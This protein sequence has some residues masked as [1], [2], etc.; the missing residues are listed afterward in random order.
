M[1]KDWVSRAYDSVYNNKDS[2]YYD[3]NKKKQEEK[4]K[5]GLLDRLSHAWNA[6]F[7]KGPPFKEEN[8]YIT[9]K[10]MDLGYSTTYRP[11]RVMFTRGQEKTFVNTIF[12]RIA[13][14]CAA[15]DIRHVK[16][17]DDDR[18]L[19]E[20]K[21]DL[22]HCLAVEANK[23][24]TARAF[25]QDI[26]MSMLDEGCVAVVPID[27]DIDPASSASSTTLS[28]RGGSQRTRLRG[29][30]HPSAGARGAPYH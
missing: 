24:Q 1:G 3:P 10:Y 17:D 26:V 29:C 16:L 22:D 2:I 21:D 18:Y 30:L 6:F 9:P 27:T 7:G 5:M 28:H 11:D 19:E 12:N 14:D 8:L 13:V 4:F 25:I 15:I 23:D 20:I